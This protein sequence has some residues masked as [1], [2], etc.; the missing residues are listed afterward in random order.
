MI[1]L[2]AENIGDFS[3]LFPAEK[4]TEILLPLFY[5]L[6]KSRLAHVR[7]LA[8]HNLAKILEVYKEDTKMQEDIIEYVQN[9]F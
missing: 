7:K 6:S 5:K 9:T 3:K 8:S 4:V 2:Y 1:D